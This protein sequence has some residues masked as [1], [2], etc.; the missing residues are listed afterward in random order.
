MLLAAPR[1]LDGNSVWYV[2]ELVDRVFGDQ[3]FHPFINLSLDQT[4][5]GLGGKIG[6]R[7]VDLGTRGQGLLDPEIR[8]DSDRQIAIGIDNRIRIRIARLRHDGASGRCAKPNARLTIPGG[9]SNAI[10]GS[11]TWFSFDAS[12]T[13]SDRAELVARR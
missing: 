4:D 3:P 2:G 13:P 12:V 1:A 11:F 5:F 7:R 8:I 6:W 9:R 10:T